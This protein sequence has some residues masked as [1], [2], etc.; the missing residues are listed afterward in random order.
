MK[1]NSNVY[2]DPV[3]AEDFTLTDAQSNQEGNSVD[4]SSLFNRIAISTFW[5]SRYYEENNESKQPQV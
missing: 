3:V 1:K 4:N 2:E 5:I